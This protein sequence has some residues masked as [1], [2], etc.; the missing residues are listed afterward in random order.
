MSI[1]S[2][3]FCLIISWLSCHIGCLV[4]AA[5]SSLA[6]NV[7][8]QLYVHILWFSCKALLSWLSCHNGWVFVVISCSV[9]TYLSWLSGCDYPAVVVLSLQAYNYYNLF[10]FSFFFVVALLQYHC[11]LT[12]LPWVPCLGVLCHSLVLAV[13]SLLS[14]HVHVHVTYFIWTITCQENMTYEPFYLC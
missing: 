5:L 11:V 3:N 4:M 13:L 6:C 10:V 2:C 7:L 14:F 12:D 1:Q 9:I 8:S